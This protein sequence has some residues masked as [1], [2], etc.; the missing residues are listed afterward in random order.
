MADQQSVTTKFNDSSAAKRVSLASLKPG[1]LTVGMREVEHKR[2]K[3]RAMTRTIDPRRLDMLK[4]AQIQAE[5]RELAEDPTQLDE[6]LAKR[7]ISVALGPNGSIYII[8]RHHLALALLKEGHDMVSIDVGDRD[9][10][11]CTE[12]QFWQKMQER[13]LLNLYDENGEKKTIADLPKN[14][15]GLRDDPYRS[16]AW[17]VREAGG[18]SKLDIPFMEFAWANYFRKSKGIRKALLNNDFDKA[19][20]LA[21]DLAHKP[22]AKNLPGYIPPEEVAAAVKTNVKTKKGRLRIR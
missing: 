16:L 11:D 6:Y 4:V 18:Y 8:D 20:R 15:E 5:L 13:K 12:E 10:S 14:L 1:Q 19:L 2:E 21:L 3:I 7:P 17:F 9:F 22:S